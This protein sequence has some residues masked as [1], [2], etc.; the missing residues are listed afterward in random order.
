MVD[1]AH[2]AGDP[3]Q[4]AV[5]VRYDE[6]R[7][8]QAGEVIRKPRDMRL[9]EKVRRLVEQQH[10]RFLEQQLREDR[11]RALPAAHL[12]QWARKADRRQPEARRD[13]F[14]PRVDPVKIPLLEQRLQRRGP[15]QTRLILRAPRIEPEHFVLGR[16]K[17]GKGRP[18]KTA[19]RHRRL[20]GGVLVEA[21]D[22]HLRLPDDAARI[23][24]KLPRADA[25]Q[26]A[27]SGA[28]RADDA[29]MLAL[30]QCKGGVSK[31]D[32]VAERVAQS[33]DFQ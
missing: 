6:K 23:R 17:L 1:V 33:R 4:K 3:L 31:Q 2:R 29:D 14:D 16:V 30:V 15:F 18:Q 5:V 11:L 21:A 24:H 26:R 25:D 28:V 9:I 32:V 10:V 22:A 20:R 8:A 27:F 7:A 12:P 13:L 19:H